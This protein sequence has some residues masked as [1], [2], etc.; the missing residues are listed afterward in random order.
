MAVTEAEIKAYLERRR[1]PCAVTEDSDVTG[2]CTDAL[3][4]LT[5]YAPLEG[6]AYFTT[7]KDVQDYNVFNP[8]SASGVAANAH[9]V[10]EVLWTPGGNPI[11]DGNIFSAGYVLLDA[12]TLN[13]AG[14]DRPADND[15]LRQ[16]LTAWSRQFG[17]GQTTSEIIG[18]QGDPTA[19]L[20]LSPVPASD[21][22]K[23]FLRMGMAWTLAN[24]DDIIT[25]EIGRYLLLLVEHQASAVAARWEAASAGI[26][27]EG[28][29][30]GREGLRFWAKE[31]ANLEKKV[32]AL[33]GGANKGLVARS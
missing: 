1:F 19:I 8:A 25:S 27:L 26:E 10:S 30:P 24:I 12:L 4:E 23:V 14:F 31:H 6:W 18:E 5:A 33:L 3:R 22:I 9:V 32:V 28:F 7:I 17:T 16:K 13:R 21:G 20:R 2:Y 29:K 15:A 11:E